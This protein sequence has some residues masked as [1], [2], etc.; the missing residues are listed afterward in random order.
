MKKII[1][2]VVMLFGMVTGIIACGKADGDSQ[3]SSNEIFEKAK[4]DETTS[5]KAKADEIS[6]ENAE[7]NKEMTGDKLEC[8]PLP[9][10]DPVVF[11]VN[12]VPFEIDLSSPNNI[13][14]TM[15]LKFFDPEGDKEV[16]AILYDESEHPIALCSVAPGGQSGA[17]CSIAMNDGTE[18]VSYSGYSDSI[19]DN[20]NVIAN[21]FYLDKDANIVSKLVRNIKYILI[22]EPE[23]EY[24]GK[25]IS[26]NGI[27]IIEDDE[28]S[29]E[30]S[31]DE[32]AEEVSIDVLANYIGEYTD[33]EGNSFK[34][35][36]GGLGYGIYEL[37][38]YSAAGWPLDESLEGT[39]FYDT[40]TI[41]SIKQG[42][43]YVIVN[44]ISQ[45]ITSEG[46]FKFLSDGTVEVIYSGGVLTGDF[47]GVF[48][49]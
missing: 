48:S 29:D 35:A 11:S 8:I 47:V 37:K 17:Y 34:I 42:A 23:S 25:R 14:V 45:Y 3:V 5:E 43:D 41:D 13:I 20:N 15:F 9:A 32:N 16:K 1:L 49:K 22:A 24:S 7:A 28:Y 10:G 44:T 19:D 31:Q 36:D 2:T 26:S 39:R 40:P 33:S 46:T 30:P 38:L 27:V 6:S 21:S 18:I 12:E 4:A